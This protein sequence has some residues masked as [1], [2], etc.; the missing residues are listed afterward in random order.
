[1]S[2]RTRVALIMLVIAVAATT[3]VAAL[4]VEITSTMLTRAA[5]NAVLR[6]ANI[7]RLAQR[8]AQPNTPRA[9]RAV[10]PADTSVQVEQG[11]SDPVLLW[12]DQS[13]PVPAWVQGRAGTGPVFFDATVDSTTYRAVATIEADGSLVVVSKDMSVAQS[14]IA[15]L[16]RQLIVVGVVVALV[17]GAV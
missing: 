3:A 6:V 17:A 12:G 8:L 9:V 2:L 7:P 11:S 16:I 5:D 10:V 4:A 1:M 15:D 14:V 13:V